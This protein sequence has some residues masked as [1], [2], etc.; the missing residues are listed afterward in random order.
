MI[1]EILAW[2]LV[3][4]FAVWAPLSA[5]AQ[6]RQ[7]W[8]RKLRRFDF[9]GLDSGMELLRAAADRRRLLH[10]LSRLGR[11]AARG[12]RVAADAAAGRAPHARHRVQPAP[13]GS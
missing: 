7:P 11:R 9:F 1:G 12:A 5:L 2:V 8:N 3:A 10:Q 13:P 6:I 4:L